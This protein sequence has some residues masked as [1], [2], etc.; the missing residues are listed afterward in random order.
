MAEVSA[1]LDDATGARREAD[2][3]VV[4]VSQATGRLVGHTSTLRSLEEDI[5]IMGLNMSLKCGRLGTIGLPLMVIAQELRAYSSH[6][7]TESGAV[8]VH[9]DRMMAIAKSLSDRAA[10]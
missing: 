7:A 3:V 4:S 10:E 6:I 1:L 2:A 8:T 5:R 9:L